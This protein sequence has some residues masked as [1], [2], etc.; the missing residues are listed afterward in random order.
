[1]TKSLSLLVLL[2]P[3][4]CDVITL[5]EDSVPACLSD[6][7]CQSTERCLDSTCRLECYG[8]G[9][10]PSGMKCSHASRDALTLDP[11][12]GSACWPEE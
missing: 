3:I 8:Y 2:I 9:D 1:M 7:D 4:A 11:W 6:L 12:D 5:P 10:C